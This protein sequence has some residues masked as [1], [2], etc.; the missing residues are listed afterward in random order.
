MTRFILKYKKVDDKY[1]EQKVINKTIDRELHKKFGTKISHRESNFS[2]NGLQFADVESDDL[3]GI[4]QSYNDHDYIEYAEEDYPVSMNVVYGTEQRVYGVM[5]GQCYIDLHRFAL[6]YNSEDQVPKQPI[7]GVPNNDIVSY[8][9]DSEYSNRVI[10]QECGYKYDG[11]VTIF[12][13]PEVDPAVDDIPVACIEFKYCQ[14]LNE[15]EIWTYTYDDRNGVEHLAS[16]PISLWYNSK[17]SNE[18]KPR[19][20]PDDPEIDKEYVIGDYALG[21][22]EN[23]DGEMA[24]WNGSSWT[25]SEYVKWNKLNAV[26]PITINNVLTPQR[27]TDTDDSFEFKK[28]TASYK[29]S[30][31]VPG[32]KECDSPLCKYCDIQSKIKFTYTKT[33]ELTYEAVSPITQTIS[34]ETPHTDM[35]TATPVFRSYG[36]LDKVPNMS[37]GAI[38]STRYGKYSN[39]YVFNDEGDQS[40]ETE[41]PIVAILDT[42][43]DYNH[44][45]LKDHCI[46][47][48]D[49]INDDNDPMDDHGHGT[50]C[51]G[52]V[53]NSARIMPIKV[54]NSNGSGSYSAIILGIGFAADNGASVCSMSLSG[55]GN[56]Q[57]LKDTIDAHPNI[58]MTCAAGN[59]GQ[60]ADL[61]PAYPAAYDCPNIISVAAV[62]DNNNLAYFSNY[63]MESVDLG[64]PGVNIY[65]TLPGNKYGE[66]SGTSMAT[67]YVSKCVATLGSKT[68]ESFF[69]H[70]VPTASL[71]GRVKYNGVAPKV[72]SRDPDYYLDGGTRVG[73]IAWD[74]DCEKINLWC[75]QAKPAM[76]P[77]FFYAWY[78]KDVVFIFTTDA[79]ATT[80]FTNNPD[81]LSNGLLIQIGNLFK[82]YNGTAWEYEA[83]WILLNSWG[84]IS[85][86]I[87]SICCDRISVNYD[88]STVVNPTLIGEEFQLVDENYDARYIPDTPVRPIYTCELSTYFA[89]SITGKSTIL[90]VTEIEAEDSDINEYIKNTT[91][92]SSIVFNSPG[93]SLVNNLY[94]GSSAFG[95]GKHSNVDS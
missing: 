82:R 77:Y 11:N 7:E 28:E 43:V 94:D 24:V 1:G 63:G 8:F 46:A 42:G 85:S 37:T 70:V 18:D 38:K 27:L 13:C 95:I 54:L 32:C 59:S 83:G 80:Y 89:D 36:Y 75:N 34:A 14:S 19:S 53:G 23:H 45:K 39:I 60:N 40:F 41:K 55:S 74:F 76:L 16:K 50:H 33:G 68:T 57:A 64:A 49:F 21:D 69:K 3:H 81:S 51:A 88:L 31:L 15:I 72:G 9:G 20:P 2:V 56:S 17:K 73:W 47:G 35:Y 92:H 61:N 65:S 87:N 6:V 44:V 4:L 5:I 86:G 93:T 26:S 78:K 84:C 62:D 66:M 22:W 52:I 25:F 90:K 29:V 30:K 79:D 12:F 91:L 10:V 48:Y 67:P 58:I 71:L